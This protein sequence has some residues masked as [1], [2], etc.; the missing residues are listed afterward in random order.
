MTPKIRRLLGA[1]LLLVP[2]ALQAQSLPKPKE[3]Y[4]DDDAATTRAIVLVEGADDA[5]IQRLMRTMDRGARDSGAAA[6][7]LARIAY[8]SGRRDTGEALYQRALEDLDRNNRL[9]PTALWNHGWDLYRAGDAAGAL[10]R[11]SEAGVERFNNPSWVPPTIALALWTLDRK[12][13]AVQWYAAA[14]RTEPGTWRAPAN[15]PALLPDWRAGEHAALA[16]VAAAWQ[17]APPAW[18]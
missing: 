9:R 3:F 11:W 17:A 7:Q 5:T 6:A 8:D 2:F 1:C 10:A 4:F 15:L 13:E 12:A 18:P 14:V 16:E